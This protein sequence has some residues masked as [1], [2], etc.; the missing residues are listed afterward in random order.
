MAPDFGGPSDSTGPSRRGTV[1]TTIL[2]ATG[3]ISDSVPP[4]WPMPGSTQEKPLDGQRAK[5]GVTGFDAPMGEDHSTRSAYPEQKTRPIRTDYILPAP[6][7]ASQEESLTE[8]WFE[9]AD[10]RRF[11]NVV[12]RLLL[13]LIGLVT[14]SGLICGFVLADRIRGNEQ[15]DDRSLARVLAH[16]PPHL[17]GDLAAA[18]G[19]EAMIVSAIPA[20]SSIATSGAATTQ[21]AGGGPASDW[22]VQVIAAE[23]I[24]NQATE[25]WLDSIAGRA[26]H[27]TA[28]QQTPRQQTSLPQFESRDPRRDT[29]WHTVVIMDDGRT[30]VVQRRQA[31]AMATAYAIIQWLVG[32]GTV[33]VIGLWLLRSALRRR[34]GAPTSALIE[35]AEDLRLRG[36]LQPNV[37][38]RL[39]S[40]KDSP[41]ELKRLARSLISIEAETRRSFDQTDS[42]LRAAGALGESLDPADV[43]AST[44]EHLEHLLGAR[45]S[46]ILQLDRRLANPRILALRGHEASF[47]VLLASRAADSTLPSVIAMKEQRPTQVPDT[48][49]E[50]VSPSL[51]RRARE[52]GYRSVL[53][54][55]LPPILEAPTVL[56]LHKDQ[57][58]TYSYDE[59]ELSVT[60]A[61]I[62]AAA[63][64]NAELFARTDQSLREQSSQ[65]EAIVESVDEGIMVEAASGQVIYS[66]AKMAELRPSEALASSGPGGTELSS[67]ELVGQIV[68]RAVHPVKATQLLDRLQADRESWVDVELVEIDGSIR[69]QR[70][71]RFDVLDGRGQIVGRGQVWTDVTKDHELQRMKTGLLAAVSH[72]FRTPLT[73]IKGYA[74]T[75]LAQDV[76][77]SETDRDEFLNL[78]VTEADRLTALVVRLLDMRRIDAGMVDLQTAPVE[79]AEIIE[80]AIDGLSHF[81]HRL[82]LGEVPDV[83]LLADDARLSTALRNLIENAC[84]YSETSQDFA[85]PDSARPDVTGPN[86]NTSKPA[87]DAQATAMVEVEAQV[88]ENQILITVSDRGPGIPDPMKEQIFG[89][90]VRG[91]NRLNA[92]HG[93]TGLGLALA[94]GFVNAHEGRLWVEDRVGGGSV[95]SISLPRTNSL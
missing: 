6:V 1:G 51:T 66:N 52:Q 47:E 21:E 72:E 50:I 86:S 71:R 57:P 17:M 84:K 65:L 44:L 5:T 26:I 42:L 16:T 82:H 62:A 49:S 58:Y 36:E 29:W 30:L 24:P 69:T 32:L 54:V 59:I 25:R 73:L 67:N 19:R 23:V 13:A 4:S 10:R 55:P 31:A 39:E 28:L 92:S 38:N 18:A 35:A 3:D 46:A 22:T 93:G 79:L 15:A 81:E 61:S 48:E 90:F 45:R 75:L 76:T 78:V 68:D 43:L 56:I 91:D 89:T 33:L 85:Q 53:A 64:R 41:I 11:I 8:V 63:L 2:R 12:N 95:F 60:F 77:W 88:S 9:S 34:I 14:I 83:I 74:T 7:T 27:Q 20:P 80:A 70:V 87:A 37:R 40:M 94:R